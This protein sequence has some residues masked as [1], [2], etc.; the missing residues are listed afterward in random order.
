M[1]IILSGTLNAF[2]IISTVIYVLGIIFLIIEAIIPGFGFFGISGISGLVLSL[3]I[4][5][6]IG[7]SVQR[8]LLE[9]VIALVVIIAILVWVIISAKKG[10]ISKTGLI[11]KGSSIPTFYNDDDLKIFIGQNGEAVTTCKPVGKIRLDNEIYDATS[12]DGFL[13]IGTKIMV[14]NVKDNT[15]EI[16]KDKQEIINNKQEIIANKQEIEKNKGEN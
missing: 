14:V 5:I 16:V 2:A 8:I 12:L 3:I 4:K 6:F 13:D 11:S 10:L 9:L 1:N 7:E 15:L